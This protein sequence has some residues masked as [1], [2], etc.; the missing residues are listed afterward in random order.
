MTREEFKVQLCQFFPES[1]VEK[2]EF[3]DT[4]LP[5]PLL[6]VRSFSCNPDGKRYSFAFELDPFLESHNMTSKTWIT[7]KPEYLKEIPCHSPYQNFEYCGENFNP[8]SA[9]L[10]DCLASAENLKHVCTNMYNHNIEHNE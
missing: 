3:S 6:I 7:I 9:R 5:Q 10:S 1:F 8:Y 4:A 2:F